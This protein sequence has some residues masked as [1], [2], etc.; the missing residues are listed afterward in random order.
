MFGC[1]G[2]NAYLRAVN[3][4]NHPRHA[5]N[6]ES[7]Y[8][9]RRAAHQLRR[10]HPPHTVAPRNGTP[11]AAHHN[12]GP[13]GPGRQGANQCTHADCA[14]WPQC[15]PRSSGSRPQSRIRFKQ[16]KVMVVVTWINPL[17]E[18]REPCSNPMPLDAARRAIR[19]WRRAI[20][21]DN[22]PRANFKVQAAPQEDFDLFD[23]DPYL[24][25]DFY[26]D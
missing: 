10:S 8:L 23:E 1:L 20:R 21:A 25:Y 16:Y 9:F 19:R 6:N 17:T 5:Q 2:R 18:L 14:H 24:F 22:R 13:P 26:D 3:R 11:D 4:S 15:R 12:H 7:K